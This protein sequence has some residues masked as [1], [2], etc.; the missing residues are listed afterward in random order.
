MFKYR[1]LNTFS[2]VHNI[3]KLKKDGLFS[4]ITINC[5]NFPGCE[6][7]MQIFPTETVDPADEDFYAPKNWGILKG[8]HQLA[9]ECLAENFQEILRLKKEQIETEQASKAEKI[10]C[11]FEGND[12]KKVNKTELYQ[13]LTHFALFF[14]C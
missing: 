9:H 3:T 4:P 2:T 10:R 7:F 6:S 13:N 5:V 12:C 11:F 8:N 14:A 1:Y